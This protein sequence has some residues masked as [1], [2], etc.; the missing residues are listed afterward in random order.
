MLMPQLRR[1]AHARVYSTQDANGRLRSLDRG[2]PLQVLQV[3]PT[4]AS[5]RTHTLLL[6]LAD[7][8]ATHNRGGAKSLVSAVS[9]AAERSVWTIDEPQSKEASG[10]QIYLWMWPSY[11]P[12]VGVRQDDEGGAAEDKPGRAAAVTP[13]GAE[14]AV[15]L[16]QD[17]Q[18]SY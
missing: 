1:Y 16:R 2:L 9:A 14:G 13:V 11:A 5:Q 17:L 10:V 3:T 8:L 18:V 12:N 15:H 6:L 7:V 4:Q